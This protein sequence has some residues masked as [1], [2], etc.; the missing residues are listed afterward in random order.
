MLPQPS[1]FI[2]SRVCVGLREKMK[3][4]LIAEQRWWVQ[5][6]TQ[7]EPWEEDADSSTV[8]GLNQADE[9]PS[10][11]CCA[12]HIS[13]SEVNWWGRPICHSVP[14]FSAIGPLNG[15]WIQAQVRSWCLLFCQ[16][17]TSF[18][19][20]MGREEKHFSSCWIPVSLFELLWNS[21]ASG[22][23]DLKEFPFVSLSSC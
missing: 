18:P 23:Y 6:L 21:Q 8:L 15:L 20:P 12:E 2:P 1:E 11:D 10:G 14:P 16:W 4:I 9:V 19:C 22:I 3:S 5:S 13:T 17:G 7:N